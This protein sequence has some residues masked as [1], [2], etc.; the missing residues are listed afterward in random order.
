MPLLETFGGAPTLLDHLKSGRIRGVVNLVGCNSPK[1][2]Y[3]ESVVRV[4]EELIAHDVLA[5][6]KGC[7]AFALLKMGFCLPEGLAGA[8][9]RPGPGLNAVLGPLK[10]PPVWHMGEC[11]DN[12]RASAFCRTFSNASGEP[13]RALPLA[14]SRPEWSNEKGV[15]AALS[16]RLLGL[17][18]YHCRRL[19]SASGWC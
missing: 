19:R 1:V 16:F 4:A 6:T 3:E 11:L 7:A 12:A 9:A 15:G 13:L 8:G 5:L 10:L 17:N 2:V 14:F 18:S